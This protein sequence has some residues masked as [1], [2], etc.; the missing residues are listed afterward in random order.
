MR[1]AFVRTV[2][3]AAADRPNVFEIAA[4]RTDRRVSCRVARADADASTHTPQNF[5]D[6]VV[7][8][9][10]IRRVR[11]RQDAAIPTS[12]ASSREQV[13]Y[14]H[15]LLEPILKDTLG[16][17]LYQEQINRIAMYVAG[18]TPSGAD[19]FPARDDPHLNRVEM[20]SLEGTSSAAA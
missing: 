12:G 15:P 7:E 6:L 18:M 13:T 9:A 2:G 10:I 3:P 11:S 5:N 17:I 16:V 4:L 20:S 14:A 8:V 19:G 1:P